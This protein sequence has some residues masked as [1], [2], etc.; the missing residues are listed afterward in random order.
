MENTETINKQNS[1]RC[2]KRI[3]FLDIDGVINSE[4]YA[5]YR[6]ASRRFNLDEF[7][8]ERAVT[9]LNYIVKKTDAKIVL[10]SSWRGNMGLISERMTKCG[11]V[12]DF[13]DKTPYHP[14]RHR[15]TEIKEWIDKY[16]ETHEPIDNYVIL[17]DDSDIL[18]EQKDHFVH[19]NNVHGLTS[20][21]S[22]KA[23][24][25]LNGVIEN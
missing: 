9:F 22:Y 13:F 6:N 15:G 21:D 20:E 4:D 3:V 7:V 23:I 11:F 16:E 17:D 14:S 25:I 1:G 24:N 5:L 10:S 18:S 2:G 8:D 19:C 12:Y